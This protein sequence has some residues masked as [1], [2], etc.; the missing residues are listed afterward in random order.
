[1]LGLP[2][3]T[4]LSRQLSKQLV[5]KKFS[6]NTKQQE[7]FDQD[8]SRMFIVNEVSPRTVAIPEGAETKL[9]FVLRVDLK[10][11]DYD[12]KNIEILSRIVPQH[13]LLVLQFEVKARLAVFRQV[14]MQTE[15]LNVEDFRITLDGSDLDQIWQ[16]V[17][18]TIGQFE[19]HDGNDLDTQIEQDE[20][21]RKLLAQIDALQKK[22]MKEQQPRKKWELMQQVKELK[23]QLE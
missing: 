4:E 23:Q 17:I 11:A 7:R 14:L 9:F 10:T 16:H 22:A 8:I 12:R 18:M 19:P 21:N 20:Q 6:L 1:M 2:E 15:W 3:R 13:L 5:Y